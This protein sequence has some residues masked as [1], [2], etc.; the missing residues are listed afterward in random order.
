MMPRRLNR[1]WIKARPLFHR[2]F[3]W[4]VPT[5]QGNLLYKDYGYHD[6]GY[7]GYFVT[8][9]ALHLGS[10][11]AMG[12]ELTA[13]LATTVDGSAHAIEF[14]TFI[15]QLDSTTRQLLIQPPPPKTPYIGATLLSEMPIHFRMAF[16]SGDA[17]FRGEVL[18]YSNSI[19]AGYW[20]QLPDDS[21]FTINKMRQFARIETKSPVTAKPWDD[22]TQ[23]YLAPMKGIVLDLSAG[24]IRFVT[25]GVLE[26]GA[27]LELA[28]TLE[29]SPTPLVI[30]G[31]VVRVF[32][33]DPHTPLLHT[34][35]V[36]FISIN[37]AQE[38]ILVKE[39]FRL[40]REQIKKMRSE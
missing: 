30:N 4:I 34:Y 29:V 28:L 2:K 12:R 14:Q 26:T 3:P 39:T 24:G 27:V 17:T 22:T 20:I 31:C 6:I 38:T 25:A 5:T 35:A 11:L 18:R 1:C 8:P 36:E 33:P 9:P 21:G 16:P 13:T 37:D 19:P 7:A 40:Q 32:E 10:L 23:G 15:K